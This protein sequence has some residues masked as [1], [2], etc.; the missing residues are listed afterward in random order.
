MIKN[1]NKQ[2]VFCS[3]FQERRIIRYLSGNLTIRLCSG[4]FHRID[5]IKQAAAKYDYNPYIVTKP[6]EYLLYNAINFSLIN[7]LIPNKKI[8]IEVIYKY[9]F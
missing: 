4:I 5:T 1:F 8:I 3:N 6:G 9:R 2:F 7:N